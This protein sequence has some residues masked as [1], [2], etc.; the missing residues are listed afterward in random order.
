MI[1]APVEVCHRRMRR[2]AARGKKRARPGRRP[3]LAGLVRDALG[4]PRPSPRDKVVNFLVSEAEREEMRGT[5]K[6]LG[7][8]LSAYLRELHRAAADA[9][10]RRKGRGH[11]QKRRQPP[12][13]EPGRHEPLA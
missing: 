11:A 12:E 6:A 1:R 7:L 8:T 2:K 13:V 10:R 4:P 5:A 9:L 3:A